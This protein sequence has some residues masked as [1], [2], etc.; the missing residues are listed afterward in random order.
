MLPPARSLFPFASG[1]PW[2]FG[3]VGDPRIFA[4]RCRLGPRFARGVFPGDVGEATAVAAPWNKLSRSRPRP[5]GAPLRCRRR[6]RGGGVLGVEPLYRSPWLGFPHL[7]EVMGLPAFW[8]ED[9]KGAAGFVEAGGLDRPRASLGGCRR[10]WRGRVYGKVYLGRVPGRRDLGDALIPSPEAG[11]YCGSIQ[12]FYALG[13]PL[14]WVRRSPELLVP[15]GRRRFP[16]NM[17]SSVSRDLVVIF[18]FSRVLRARW[19]GQLSL[20][21]PS[22]WFLYVRFWLYLF[23]Y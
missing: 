12:S 17:K 10:R 15:V 18:N 19:F 14:L 2:G 8:S 20:L 4:R 5:A 3:C 1:A 9:A 16:A 7:G 22:S 6:A 23:M 13:F 11:V 21:Y